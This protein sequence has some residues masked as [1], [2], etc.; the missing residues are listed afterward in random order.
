MTKPRFRLI[1]P[2][3]ILASA[4]S[5]CG[6][7]QTSLVSAALEGSVSDSSGGRITAVK[8]TVREV[9]THQS[10]E[11]STNGEGTFHI[12]GLPPGTYAVSAS[13]PGFG[14]FKHA[15]V[16]LPLGA[17]VHLD[18]VLESEGVTTQVMVTAQPPAIDPA[19]TSVSS[20]VDK[21]RIEELPVE[22]RNYL[23]FAL[24][25]PGVASSAQQP[26]KQSLVPLPDSGFTFGGLRGRSNNVTIDGLDNNDEY[27]G[28]SRTE[29]SLETVQEFQVVNAGL[30]AETGG[31][32][33]GSINVVTR[34]GGNTMHGDAFLFLQNGS[35]MPAIRS[36]LKAPDRTFTG[37]APGW[38]WA[39][40]SSKTRRSSTPDLS[41]NTA[42]HWKIPSSL[43][44]WKARS[45]AH[46]PA[47]SLRA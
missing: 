2:A 27:V 12:S 31:A 8:V 35:W 9:E 39:A 10:R 30:S 41:R 13:Q 32:S 45:I 20:A 36:R 16:M 28:S 26:G 1:L 14:P 34:V 19:Q 47:A 22:S 3:L 17:T 33:G 37:I 15:G 6:R 11:V 4:F 42:G 29:L 5:P 44:R 25:A 23:N 7:T 21:E 43:G 18:I 46:W 38:P 40:Q 24:L